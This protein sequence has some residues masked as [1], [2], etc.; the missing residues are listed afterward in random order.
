MEHVLSEVE[1]DDIKL[2]RTRW[3]TKL[4]R[5]NLSDRLYFVDIISLLDSDKKCIEKFSM[6]IDLSLEPEV[7]VWVLLVKSLYLRLTC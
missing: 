6:K 3:M 1:L 7:S 4:S 5:V 2:M